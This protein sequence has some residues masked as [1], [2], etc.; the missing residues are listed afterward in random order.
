M[1]REG[2]P[3]ADAG[4]GAAGDRGAADVTELLSVDQA[5]AAL[6]VRK[7]RRWLVEFLHKTRTDPAGRPLYRL[8]GR[9]KLIYLDRLIEA[10]EARGSCVYFV[11]ASHFVKIG[12][13]R[14]LDER[15]HKM[16]TDV[17]FEI[18]IL[19]FEPGTAAEEKKLHRRFAA[20][21]VR[22]EWFRRS[23]ELLAFIDARKQSARLQNGCRR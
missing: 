23:P 8:A 10:I 20:I 5:I 3:A 14:A 18:E 13:S 15:L 9:D 16:R 2:R 17:P 11:G 21:R 6:P 22:G 7:S 19:H 12:F 1:G 4:C